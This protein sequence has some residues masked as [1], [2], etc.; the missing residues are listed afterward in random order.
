MT[1]A[2]MTL[3]LLGVLSVS[4]AFAFLFAPRVFVYWPQT[5]G[6]DVLYYTGPEQ[7]LVALTIDDSPSGEETD[8]I[9]AVLDKHNVAATFFVIGVKAQMYETVLERI[10]EGGHEIA[11]HG[12][13]ATPSIDLDH[14]RFARELARTSELLGTYAPKFMR[15][16][17]GLYTSTIV[18]EVKAQGMQTVLADIYPA[19]TRIHSPAFFAWYLEQNVRPGSI[20]VLHDGG[21]GT[22]R[23]DRTA[24]ALDRVL[25][26]LKAAGFEF[27]SLS[28]LVARSQGGAK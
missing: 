5:F 8:R 7:K 13:D 21:D 10:V 15:P 22:G 25:P 26:R 14:D 23:G 11:N 2:R 17:S 27:V 4:V 1:A 24:E 19:D 6:P 9:L 12:W 16:A 20:I 3:T 18:A 28:A